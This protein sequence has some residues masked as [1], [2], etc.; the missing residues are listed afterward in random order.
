MIK[1]FDAQFKYENKQN[2]KKVQHFIIKAQA[3]KKDS[4]FTK[5]NW[6]KYSSFYFYIS[7]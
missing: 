2:V 6:T 3:Q 1:S 5:I 7:F 4:K